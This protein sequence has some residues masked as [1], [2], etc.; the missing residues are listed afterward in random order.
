M[1]SLG[2]RLRAAEL[3]EAHARIAELEAALR[4]IREDGYHTVKVCSLECR[5]YVVMSTSPAERWETTMS[6]LTE[7]LRWSAAGI[8]GPDSESAGKKPPPASTNSKRR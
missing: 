5:D 2:E 3:A 8:H 6:D 4:E 1:K 7:R